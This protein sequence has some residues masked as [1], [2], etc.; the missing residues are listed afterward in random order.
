MT[1]ALTPFNALC[2][3]RPLHSLASA[4]EST[5]E[6]AA[7]I[8]ETILQRF[9]SLAQSPT[10]HGDPTGPAEKAA[11]RDVF[12]A[13]MTA[14]TDTYTRYLDALISRYKASKVHP[15]EEVE[16][17]AL[18]LRLNNQFPG[19]IGI[20][21]AFL[22]NYVSLQ[23]GEAIFLGAGEPHAYVFGGESPQ[24]VALGFP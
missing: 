1:V 18:V 13:V 7:L 10:A 5:P 15:G 3:F 14:P 12:S 6:L 9:L 16:R 4:L 24:T 19:D 11:L 21:C 17:I 8:P 23:P 2:G 22:L 20:F